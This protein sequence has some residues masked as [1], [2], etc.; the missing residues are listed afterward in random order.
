MNH[1]DERNAAFQVGAKVFVT[2]PILAVGPVANAIDECR[3]QAIELV[4]WH[5]G[6]LVHDDSSQS[7]ADSL[8]HDPG[9]AVVNREPFFHN[10]NASAVPDIA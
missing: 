3:F 2:A 10:G 4:S 8:P 5:I 1:L 7:L 6:P 9:L